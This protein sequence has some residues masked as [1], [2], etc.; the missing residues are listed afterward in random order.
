V[1]VPA[2]HD[3]SERM[4][5]ASTCTM[6]VLVMFERFHAACSAQDW[7]EAERLRLLVLETVDA[8]LDATAAVFK[9][10]DGKEA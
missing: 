7:R 5:R 3:M 2:F 6:S 4:A 10:F 9:V 1:T 8:S